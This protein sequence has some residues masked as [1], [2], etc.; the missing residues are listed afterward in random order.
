MKT[1]TL[2]RSLAADLRGAIAR[3]DYPP[4]SRL[5]TELE[6]C[7]DRDVSRHTAREALRLLRE[8]GLIVRR[9][10]AGTLVVDATD[11][12]PFTQTVGE[13]NALLQYAREARL[14]VLQ[15]ATMSPPGKIAQE[16]GLEEEVAWTR[17]DGMR[18]AENGG[19]PIALTQVYVR[20]DLCPSRD[21]IDAWPGALNELITQ[22]TGVAPNRITQHIMAVE[23]TRV[24]ARRLDADPQTPAL[25][26]VR[27]YFDGDDRVILASISLHPGERF[28]YAMEMKR[29]RT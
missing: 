21:A 8:E 1:D 26:T 23:L 7:A 6:L 16:L 2:Y 24:D 5:P 11:Q 13:M 12:R 15:I 3:G 17:L 4:G 10:G 28:V 18:R 29:E 14:E 22:Q 25:R 27:R 9:R 19:P 20:A